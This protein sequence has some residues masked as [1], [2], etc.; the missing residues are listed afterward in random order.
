MDL[1]MRGLRALVTG[2]SS[3]VGAAI[4]ER[5]AAEGC[6]VI[7]HGRRQQ[8]AVEQAE[9]IE[10][11]SGGRVEVLLGDLTAPGGPARLIEQALARGPV[12][13]LVA[14]AGPFVEHRF[15]EATDEDWLSAFTGNVTSAVGCARAV[16]PGMRSKGWGRVIA[17]E[18]LA[19]AQ[20]T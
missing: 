15:A 19:A 11:S 8:P 18:V 12:D 13:V 17:R 4:A 14:N 9:S 1:Q 3:G 2:S 16:I 5:L 7:V 10:R 20:L 6:D